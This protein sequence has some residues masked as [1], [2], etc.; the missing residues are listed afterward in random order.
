MFFTLLQD[1][2]FGEC[3]HDILEKDGLCSLILLLAKLNVEIPGGRGGSLCLFLL[4]KKKKSCYTAVLD[5]VRD[6]NG[7][8]MGD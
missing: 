8:V 4:V 3:G 2:Q 5:R 7:S 1:F 6:P